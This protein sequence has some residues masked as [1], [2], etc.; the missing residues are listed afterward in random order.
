MRKCVFQRQC[1]F[2]HSCWELLGRVRSQMASQQQLL[3]QLRC[4]HVLFLCKKATEITL[5]GH[6]TV[7]QW[8]M[9]AKAFL[10]KCSNS[11]VFQSK[12]SHWA[13]YYQANLSLTAPPPLAVD[14][15][16]MSFEQERTQ[17]CTS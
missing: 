11:C 4:A 16:G 13:M 5:S 9:Y 10:V 1:V 12:S 14:H 15:V 7:V 2:S 6:N 3:R 8:R 17:E